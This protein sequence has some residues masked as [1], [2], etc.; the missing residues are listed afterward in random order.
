MAVGSTTVD[1]LQLLISDALSIETPAPD[2]D[3][4]DSGLVD[5]LALVTMIAGIE[6]EF[7]VELPLDDF[8]VDRF[9]SVC[10]IAEFLAE[11]DPGAR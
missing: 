3:L 6:Q 5:S 9:R 11:I 8:E 4:I 7:G 10:R 1:R 2:T